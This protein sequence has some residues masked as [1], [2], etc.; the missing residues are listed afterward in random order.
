MNNSEELRKK[1][2]KICREVNSEIPD[3]DSLLL[4]ENGYVD[5]FG[6]FVIMASIEIEFDI[7]VLDEEMN[8][9]NFKNINNIVRLIEKHKEI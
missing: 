6:V 1:V 2:L 3:D 5:S 4:I 9:D 7:K 8:Q